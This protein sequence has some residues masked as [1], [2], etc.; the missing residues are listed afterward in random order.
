[1]SEVRGS[2][3]TG[4]V[5]LSI[6][7]VNWNSCEYLKTCIDSIIETVSSVCYEI[8]VV[9]AGSF[10]G[11][12][13]MLRDCHPRVRFLQLGQNV[14]FARANNLAFGISTGRCLLFLNPD[15]RPVGAAIDTM[16]LSLAALPDTGILGC[17]LINAD[18]TL[19]TSCV[20]SFPTIANQFLDS[21]F[22][23]R[24]WPR[25]T[26]WGM[27]ALFA[28][29]QS[30]RQVEALS[31]A[32]LMI[33]RSTFEHVGGFSEEYFMY[34]E[35]MD[36]AYKVRRAGLRNYYVPAATV[37]HFGGQSSQNAGNTFAAVML[38]EAVRRFLR[39]TKGEAYSLAYRLMML[40]SASGRLCVLGA[41][42]LGGRGAATATS[43]RKWY[44]VLQWTV[45]CDGIVA[46]YYPDGR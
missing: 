42:R 10:D 38:P 20:Q 41:V 14:G 8:V 2:A 27:A 46:K 6:V 23:R 30:P 3:V 25:S 7:I 1:M 44:A 5:E 21:E 13:A 11:C 4:P 28:D 18:G 9:D 22:L 19:Q 16:Y 35:D 36:L 34:A 37:I 33:S 17:R 31:G 12:D 29:D 43:W 26:L 45:N 15:T 24:R 39:K 32:C 40:L